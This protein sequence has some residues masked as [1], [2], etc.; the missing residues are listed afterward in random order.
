MQ[1]GTYNTAAMY[2]ELRGE[3]SQVHWRKMFFNNYVR[4]IVKFTRWLNILGKIATKHR[5]QKYGVMT[6]NMYCFCQDL[7]TR[8]H[9]FFGCKIIGSIWQEI[10]SWIGYSKRP[11]GWTKVMR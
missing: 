9:L 6:D 3:K 1:S 5:I 11:Q 8:E 4:P 2:K 10:L 7:E